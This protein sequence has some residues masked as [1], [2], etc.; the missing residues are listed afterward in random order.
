MLAF[1]HQSGEGVWHALW[2]LKAKREEQANYARS[3]ELLEFVGLADK[4]NDLA[5]ALSYGQQKLV[6]LACCLAMDAQLL[7]LDEPVAGIDPEM[8]QRMLE[9]LGE[10]KNQ[11]KTIFL[12]EHNM[13][14]VKAISDKVIVMDE[15]RKIAEGTPEA[16]MQDAAVLEA[17]LR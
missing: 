7:L 15:G 14:A 17:Y 11:G 10:L 12:I 9:L 5:E 6:T 2:G 3:L 1:Q 16:V 13:E 8:S 4:K